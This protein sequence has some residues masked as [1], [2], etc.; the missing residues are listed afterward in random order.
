MHSSMSTGD[1]GRISDDDVTRLLYWMITCLNFPENSRDPDGGHD[2]RPDHEELPVQHELHAGCCCLFSRLCW[3]FTNLDKF[4]ASLSPSALPGETSL[5]SSPQQQ[6]YWIVQTRSPPHC[7]LSHHENWNCL[8][9]KI[10]TSFGPLWPALT[11]PWV[12]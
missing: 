10:P 12:D 2:T 1:G 6:H 9:L 8:E 7:D 4:S 5:S 11:Y 3:H